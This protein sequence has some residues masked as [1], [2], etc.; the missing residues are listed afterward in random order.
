MGSSTYLRFRS[1]SRSP[2]EGAA[3]AGLVEHRKGPAAK[4]QHHDDDNDGEPLLLPGTSTEAMNRRQI[5]DCKIPLT[6]F[7]VARAQAGRCAGPTP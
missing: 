5:G 3:G 2:D 1:A 4:T 7:P 6:M